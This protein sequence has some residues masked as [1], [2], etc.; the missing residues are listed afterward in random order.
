MRVTLKLVALLLLLLDWSISCCW[1]A[2]AAR[3]CQ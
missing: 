1:C 2:V 3:C